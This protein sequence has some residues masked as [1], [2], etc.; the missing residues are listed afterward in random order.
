MTNLDLLTDAYR[1]LNIIDENESPT[2]E[3]GVLGLRKLNQL[4]AEWGETDLAFPSWFEQTEQ[5]AELPL[6]RW[7][8]KAVMYALC[9]VLAPAFGLSVTP[10]LAIVADNSRTIAL[11]RALNRKLQP[12]DVTDLPLGEAHG[13][14][15]DYRADS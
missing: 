15:Y 14:T 11:R 2:A 9:L 1:E 7:A 5:S 6:P 12:I 8:E 10:E 4:M 3:Q 13:L